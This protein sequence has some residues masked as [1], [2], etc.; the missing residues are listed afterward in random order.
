[1]T[2]ALAWILL[3][4]IATLCGASAEMHAEKLIQQKPTK[5]GK[6]K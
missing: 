2:S 6:N 5:D 3:S 1:M 4:S